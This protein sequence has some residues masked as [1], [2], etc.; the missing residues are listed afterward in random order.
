MA[1]RAEPEVSDAGVEGLFHGSNPGVD[2]EQVLAPG[3]H[4]Q[5]K[6]IAIEPDQCVSAAVHY[7]CDSEIF[8][9]I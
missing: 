6:G 4:I 3:S 7:V 8:Q 9:N 2:I 5:R 1:L